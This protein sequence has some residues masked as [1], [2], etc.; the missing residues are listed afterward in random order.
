MACTIDCR[1]FSSA[2]QKF[3]WEHNLDHAKLR[4]QVVKVIR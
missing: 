1:Q 3:E 4:I 2:A